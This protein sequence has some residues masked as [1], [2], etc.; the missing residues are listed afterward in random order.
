MTFTELPETKFVLFSVPRSGTSYLITLLRSHED[1]LCHGEALLP[2]HFDNHIKG[3]A[4]I[5][6]SQEECE[7]DPITFANRLFKIHDSHKVVGYKVFEGH[8]PSAHPS[9]AENADIKKII[10]QRDNA[11]ASY[12]SRLVAAKSGVWNSSKKMDLDD[13]KVTFKE[14]AFE[15]Y[16]NTIDAYFARIREMCKGDVLE[17]RYAENILQQNTDP[18]FD[19]LG[20]ENFESATSGLKKQLSADVLDRFENTADVQR[21]LDKIGHPEWA[22]E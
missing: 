11:L 13:V 4:Q 19:F 18:V 21:F 7:N 20:L 10:L 3:S 6:L 12:S 15:N 22:T 8:S 16:L 9:L 14:D 17:L 2:R 1:V 5:V